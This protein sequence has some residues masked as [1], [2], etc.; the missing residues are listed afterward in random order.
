[1]NLRKWLGIATGIIGITM[2]LLPDLIT[3]IN[4][5]TIPIKNFDITITSI[6]LVITGAIMYW[7]NR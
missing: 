7:D 5:I 1:M 2:I 3:K 6:I 4:Q